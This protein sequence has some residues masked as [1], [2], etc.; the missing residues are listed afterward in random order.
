MDEKENSDSQSWL[1][2]QSCKAIFVSLEGGNDG[3]ESLLSYHAIVE[4]FFHPKIGDLKEGY[5][6]NAR[7]Q[8]EILLN[9]VRNNKFHKGNAR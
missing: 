9:S 4:L 5:V 7:E 2:N 3:N 1:H 8:R 6:Y